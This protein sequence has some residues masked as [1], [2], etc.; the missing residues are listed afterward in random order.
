M[1]WI[2]K[3][4]GPLEQKKEYRR[5]KARMAAL[6]GPYDEVGRA[7]ER[8]LTYAG[9][10]TGGDVLMRMLEDLVVL[11]EESA[12]DGTPV[13][14]LMGEDPVAFVEDFL[15]NYDEGRWIAKERARFREAIADA[16][17]EQAHES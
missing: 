5:Y 6:P 7:I 9:A 15:S 1:S 10:I 3:L 11:L 2:E 16:A 14:A 4:T 13:H 8:Y 12:A 17:D